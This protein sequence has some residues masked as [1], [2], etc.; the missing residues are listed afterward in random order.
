LDGFAFPENQCM[1]RKIV[2]RFCDNDMHKNKKLKRVM[3]RF[4]SDLGAVPRLACAFVKV[5]RI[6][7]WPLAT[8]AGHQD[9]FGTSAC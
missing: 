8:A 5:M 7:A 6:R 3:T 9:R 1:S 2:Q 4:S